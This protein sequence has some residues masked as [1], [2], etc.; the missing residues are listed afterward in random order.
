MLPVD[1]IINIGNYLSITCIRK[2][3]LTCKDYYYALKYHS[4][5]DH[6][7]ILWKKFTKTLYQNDNNTFV[8]FVNFARESAANEGSKIYKKR[9]RMSNFF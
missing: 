7:R 6:A 9:A 1:I 2:L 3:Q 5:R 8:I 4:D